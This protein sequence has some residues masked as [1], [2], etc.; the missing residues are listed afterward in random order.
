MRPTGEEVLECISEIPALTPEQA[1][2]ESRRGS[3]G[4]SEQFEQIH[5]YYF[6]SRFEYLFFIKDNKHVLPGLVLQCAQGGHW[7]VS[8]HFSG[9]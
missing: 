1:A 3:E 6:L 7:T 8:V 2:V 9:V 4:G 5:Y